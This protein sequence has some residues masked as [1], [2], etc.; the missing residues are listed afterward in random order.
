MYL[1][2]LYIDTNSQEIVDYAK[3]DGPLC[4]TERKAG[5]GKNSAN[6]NDLLVHHLMSYPGLGLLFQ[7]FAVTA[8]VYAGRNNK[9]QGM[10]RQYQAKNTTLFFTAA[11]ENMFLLVS[12]E[13]N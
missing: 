8:R 7:L 6:G 9:I 5:T 10:K 3:P 13:S 11:V 1:M 4:V 2:I 12:R